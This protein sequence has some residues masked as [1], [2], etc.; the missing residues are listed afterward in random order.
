MQI[1]YLVAA[2]VTFI[3]A[4]LPPRWELGIQKYNPLFAVKEC[5]GKG[6]SNT[7]APGLLV[8][9]RSRPDLSEFQSLLS[10]S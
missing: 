3:C 5:L 7:T 1:M 2:I 4:R 10:H 6:K 8:A 9:R